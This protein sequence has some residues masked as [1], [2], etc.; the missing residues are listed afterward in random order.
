MI[1]EIVVKFLR[2]ILCGGMQRL[3]GVGRKSWKNIGKY[4][5]L[6][7]TPSDEFDMHVKLELTGHRKSNG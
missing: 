2:L 4:V 3:I 1:Q 7:L 5:A 6:R